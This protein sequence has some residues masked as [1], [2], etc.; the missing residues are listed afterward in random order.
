[1]LNYCSKPRI[2]FQKLDVTSV[3]LGAIIAVTIITGQGAAYSAN[4]VSHL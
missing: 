1:M 3:I 4:W 2:A